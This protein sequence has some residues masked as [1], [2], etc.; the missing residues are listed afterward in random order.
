MITLTFSGM[1]CGVSVTVA[2]RPSSAN[3]D[4]IFS[5]RD[6][7]ARLSA[8]QTKGSLS[9]SASSMKA[10]I[11]A[12]QGAGA[13]LAVAG[14]K[15]ALVGAVF[16]TA[17]QVV[18]GR[19]RL[20]HHRRAAIDRVAD[21]QARAVLLLEQHAVLCLRAVL[22]DQLLDHGLQ[23]VDLHRLQISLNAGVLGILFRKGRQQRLQ[24]LTDGLVIE[25]AQLVGGLALP[26]REAGQLF[27][28]PHFQR[29]NI[30]V[31]TLAL[32]FRQLSE[33]GLVQ[34]LAVLHRGEGDIGAVAV[35]GDFL[36]ERKLR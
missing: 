28:Q 1:T 16:D 24:C 13:Q 10:A 22:V 31:V 4:S 9:S 35:E 19:V 34:R 14:I 26:L 8:S 33:F 5:L 2:R 20:E 23:Q 7:R 11:G 29:G 15:R 27:V 32:G 36:L 3:G 17:E 12:M 21:H 25:L 30:F 6:C 18:E